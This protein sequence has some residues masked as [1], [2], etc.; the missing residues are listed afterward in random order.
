M[1]VL[2]KMHDAVAKAEALESD[3]SRLS[4]SSLIYWLLDFVQFALLP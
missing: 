2:G 3:K 1:T 4:S